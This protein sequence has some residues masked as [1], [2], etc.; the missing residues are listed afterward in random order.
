MGAGLWLHT[1]AGTGSPISTAQKDVALQ[2]RTFVFLLGDKP[3]FP[4]L[5][6]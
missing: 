6:H 5:Q 1:T 2:H 4:L 3:F